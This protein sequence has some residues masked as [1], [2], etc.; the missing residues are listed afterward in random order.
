MRLTII[1]HPNS[2]NPRIEEDMLGITH[3]YVKEPPL[4]GKANK[5]VVEA[6]SKH[7]KK[8]KGEVVMVRGERSKSK[9]F[10]ID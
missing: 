7:F 2:K 6:L 5:S 4:E 10:E 1:V 8:K 9:I 3:V